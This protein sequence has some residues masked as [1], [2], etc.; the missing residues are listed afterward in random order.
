MTPALEPPIQ[1]LGLPVPF[2]IAPGFWKDRRKYHPKALWS[3]LITRG[4]FCY[5]IT[6]AMETQ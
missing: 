3:L 5:L 1:Q 4:L 2:N 6:M